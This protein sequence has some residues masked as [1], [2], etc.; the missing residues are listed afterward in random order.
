MKALY[1][2]FRRKSQP[3]KHS[4]NPKLKLLY[5]D[6]EGRKY[7]GFISP[8]ENLSASRAVVAESKMRY[9]QLCITQEVLDDICSKIILAANKQRTADVAILANDLKTR[10]S[11]I[12]EETTL[13]DLAA[14]YVLSESE[15]MGV[16]DFAKIENWKADPLAKD[17][18]LLMAFQL[19]KQFSTISAVDL[20]KYLQE[21]QLIL[22]QLN[23]NLIMLRKENTK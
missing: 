21:S 9:A 2:L 4:K 7:Y 22:T 6:S 1:K 17:F 5:T 3:I 18:F 8:I 10:N 15:G 12:A 20:Q 11:L 16:V 19:T 23:N 14:C 13:L